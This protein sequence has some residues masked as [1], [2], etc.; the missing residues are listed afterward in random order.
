MTSHLRQRSRGGNDEDALARWTAP[1]ARWLGG[2]QNGARALEYVPLAAKED[3]ASSPDDTPAPTTEELP[4]ISA[5]SSLSRLTRMGLLATLLVSIIVAIAVYHPPLVQFRQL[6][7]LRHPNPPPTR[8]GSRQF[9]PFYHGKGCN[10]T[11]LVESLARSRIRP[12]GASRTVY[13]HPEG[14]D[15]N[16]IHLDTFDFSFNL[17]GCPPPHAFSPREACDLV[18]AFGGIFNRGDSLMR[19]FAQGLFMLLANSLDLVYA[20]K[21]ECQGTRI[22]TNG[23]FCKDHSILTSLDFA[24]V[25]PEQPYVI[26]R[27]THERRDGEAEPDYAAPLLDSWH[28][29]VDQLPPDRQRHSPI[30]VEATGIHY[31]WDANATLAVHISPFIRNTSSLIPRPIPFFS[32]YPAVPPNKPV[33]WIGIQGPD[34]TQRYNRE[35]LAALDEVSPEGS[36]DGGWTMLQWYNVTDGAVSYDGTHYDYQVAL[37]R[38]QIFLN[39]L[40]ALWGEIVDSGGLVVVD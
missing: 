10:S 18:S 19:Q 31:H 9:G 29:F 14:L 32:G 15:P 2:A 38:A 16:D 13:A 4:A 21:D 37:E 20:H 22:F 11:Q 23:T 1:L 34:V 40:D 28:R 25:C 7:R 8:V 26:W 36:I 35:M 24:H 12:D 3:E 30:F 33:Q 6:Y 39:V 17:D 5:S 27:F